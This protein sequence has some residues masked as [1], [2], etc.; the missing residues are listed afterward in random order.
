MFATFVSF[1]FVGYETGPS[2]IFTALAL[3]EVLRSSVG[4]LLPWGIQYFLNALDTIRRMQVGGA[5]LWH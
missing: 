5:R 4:L 1:V 2:V 3:Y